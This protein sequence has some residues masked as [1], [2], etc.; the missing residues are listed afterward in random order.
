MSEGSTLAFLEARERFLPLQ[1]ETIL[2]RV[3]ADPRFSPK[4]RD[5]FQTLMEMIQA[6]F[7]FEF[8]KDIEKLKRAYDPFD[9]DCDTLLPT[10]PSPQDRDAHYE[11]LREGFRKLLVD[12]NYVELTRDQLLE[13]LQLQTF[14]GLLVKVNLD[15]Y[16][17]LH[18]FYRGL[19]D[20]LRWRRSWIPPWKKIP[21]KVRLFKRVALLVRT[22]EKKSDLILFKLFKDVVLEDLKMITPRLRIQMRL[23]DKLKVGSTVVGGLFA[24][25]L[26]IVMAAAFSPILLLIVVGGC[27]GAFVKGIFSFLT[28]KTKYMQ[29]LSSSLYFQN[30]ANNV[31]ALTRLVDAAEAEEAKELLLAYFILYLERG[32]DYTLRELDKRVEQWLHEQFRIDVDFEA[33]DAVRKLA[34]KGLLVEREVPAAPVD[35]DDGKAAQ[36]TPQAAGN[37]QRKILKVYDLPTTLRRLDAWWD[38]YFSAS[39]HGRPGDDRIADAQW[40]PSSEPPELGSRP[41]EWGPEESSHES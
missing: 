39:E 41:R 23:F 36:S 17:D 16:K 32:R 3:L 1:P 29:T 19:R 15:E 35:D 12:G 38:D 26:K 37:L 21:R 2:E 27:L 40:P 18:V 20:D 33:G 30:L 22:A 31:S 24:P 5:Q 28:C 13:C 9:P 34:E 11:R 8:Q 4:E 6:R 25:V 14:A 10:E 7:H